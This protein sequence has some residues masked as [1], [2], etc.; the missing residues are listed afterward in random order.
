MSLK[1]ILFLLS[2]IQTIALISS[3]N[4][5]SHQIS[6]DDIPAEVQV[7]IWEPFYETQS[8]KIYTN[9]IKHEEVMQTV[10]LALQRYGH[11]FLAAVEMRR[12]F[13]KPELVEKLAA[14]N[15]LLIDILYPNPNEYQKQLRTNMLA[16]LITCSSAYKPHNALNILGTTCELP[17][18]CL[19]ATVR[20]DYY[21]NRDND[22]FCNRVKPPLELIPKECA[23]YISPPFNH[24]ILKYDDKDDS[25]P[26]PTDIIVDYYAIGGNNNGLAQPGQK[27]WHG[28]WDKDSDTIIVITSIQHYAYRTLWSLK[29][30]RATSGMQR[31][32][33]SSITGY[34]NTDYRNNPNQRQYLKD[35]FV[36]N[37]RAYW[38]DF[39]DQ[40]ILE[41]HINIIFASKTKTIQNKVASTIAKYI[42]G[43]LFKAGICVID[44]LWGFK[45]LPIKLEYVDTTAHQNT[46]LKLAPNGIAAILSSNENAKFSRHS[47]NPP[48]EAS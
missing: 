10:E 42:V 30:Y 36:E 37:I 23:A 18:Q 48:K 1:K 24:A 26:L 29:P 28:I 44:V 25:Y 19:E 47:L 20:I 13:H 6:I 31:L 8:Q 27:S 34:Y 21:A 40:G 16:S 41:R 11:R 7:K 39:I 22:A 46:D 43:P 17:K 14:H 12:F 15:A 4:R 33:L 9:K 35:Q 5:S 2:F 45:T 3:E 32:V 38:D